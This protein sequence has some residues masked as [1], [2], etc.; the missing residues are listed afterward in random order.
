MTDK[1]HG[2]IKNTDYDGVLARLDQLER[3]R[4]SDAEDLD[5]LRH[6]LERVCCAL[7]SWRIVLLVLFAILTM[8]LAYLGARS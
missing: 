5:K 3:T 6:G 8:F 7:V 2:K 4:D 1:I